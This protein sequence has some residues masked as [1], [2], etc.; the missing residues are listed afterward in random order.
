[1]LL[2]LAARLRRR[3]A[4]PYALMQQLGWANARQYAPWLHEPGMLLQDVQQYAASRLFEQLTL[5]IPWRFTCYR[6]LILRSC[7]RLRFTV[8]EQSR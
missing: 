5:L 1:M 7:N 6:A 3:N 2:Q 8:S 4:S